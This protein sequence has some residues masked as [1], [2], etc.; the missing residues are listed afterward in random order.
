MSQ[1]LYLESI[2]G[3]AGD[4]FAASFI[5]AG[6][7]SEDEI[8]ALPALLGI[9]EIETNISKTI[10]ANVQATHIKIQ[11]KSD[12]W[13]KKFSEKQFGSERPE[14]N[15]TNILL[16]QSD[17]ETH[18]HT[19]FGQINFLI[20]TS[21]LDQNVK[22]LA[23]KI[24]RLIAEAESKV[25]GVD[26]DDV[27]FHEIGT[28]DSILD[29]VMAAFCVCKINPSNVYASP[30]KLGRGKIKIAHGVHAIPPPASV[31]LLVNME[32]MKTPIEIVNENIELST[33][34]GIAIL[35]SLSPYFCSEMPSGKVLATGTGAGTMDLGNYPNVFRVSL[36]DD[37]SDSNLP[38][39]YDEVI[40]IVCNI[41]D[42]TAEKIAW[43]TEQLLELKALDVWL[44]PIFGKK[45]R[46][47]TMLSVIAAAENWEKLADWILRNSSTFGIRH[48]KWNRLKLA[49]HFE[50]R[51]SSEGVIS[52]KIGS[53]IFGNKIKEKPEY[54]EIRKTWKK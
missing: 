4:M 36:L 14:E 31:K 10:R 11:T 12:T 18:F 28:I 50:Q 21:N 53:D 42:D 41:D 30:L 51:E 44:T 9:E 23:L 46:P 24:F 2:A 20:E 25:H 52:Y 22:V 33:P 39:E 17:Q 54:E 32:I 7:V 29:V 3:V 27:A 26:L 5:D 40:E 15:N 34:T 49:R 19:Y 48:Q 45:G 38:Y 6:L 13:K 47:A 1:I 8:K 35:K 37:N 43:L 16:D